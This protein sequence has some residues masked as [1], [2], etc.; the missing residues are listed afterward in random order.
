MNQ[1]SK[2]RVLWWTMIPLVL[3]FLYAITGWPFVYAVFSARKHF[4]KSVYPVAGVVFSVCFYPH[5][6]VMR[7]QKWYYDYI[8]SAIKICE[9]SEGTRSWDE[10]RRDLEDYEKAE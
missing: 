4:P 5:E 6:W 9:P 10:Y 2:R 7:K 8:N 3:I 1:E